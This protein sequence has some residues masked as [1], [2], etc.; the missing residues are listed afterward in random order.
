MKA[1][2]KATKRPVEI[3]FIEW[4]GENPR[5]VCEFMNGLSVD[6]CMLTETDNFYIDHSQLGG[7]LVIKTSEGDMHANRGDMIIKEPFDK[8]RMFYPC[9]PDIFKLTYDIG[10]AS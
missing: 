4:T 10:C 2:M 6:G 9:K 3:D 5:P 1:P 7:G 8:D